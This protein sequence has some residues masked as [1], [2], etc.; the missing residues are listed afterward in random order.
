MHSIKV[1]KKELL[2]TIKKNRDN[3]HSVYEE[4]FEG[5]RKECIRILEE[6]LKLLKSGKKVVVAFFEQAP[7]DHTGEYNMVIRMLEMDVDPIVELDQQQFSNYVDDNWN[8]KQHWNL[9]NTKY[10]A[11]LSN[12]NF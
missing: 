9:S 1:D 4:A 11:S 8:W 7:Q 12:S 2:A 6:N 3:H 5:Y 10:A